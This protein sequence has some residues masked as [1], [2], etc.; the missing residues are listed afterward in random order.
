MPKNRE[1]ATGPDV[2][3]TT[4]RWSVHTNVENVD[5]SQL[6]LFVKSLNHWAPYEFVYP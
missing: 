2:D 5:V 4:G 3:T 1:C 6:L